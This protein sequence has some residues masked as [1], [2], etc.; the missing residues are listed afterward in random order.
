MAL[1]G[2]G[3]MIWNIRSCESGNADQIASVAQAA[4]LTNVLIKVADAAN[5]HNVDRNTKV[6]LVPPVVSALKA[7]GMQV[8]GWHYVYGYNPS[9]E[10]NTAVKRVTELGLD[11]YIID[12][13]SE[14]KL[15]G[16]EDNAR[17]FMSIV[18][19]GL[20]NIPIALCSYR[21]PSYHP[22]L[23][24][25]AFLEKCDYNMP[26]VYWEKADNPGPQLQ[27]SVR[28]FNALTPVRPV[29][30]T[31][32]IYKSGDW[33]AKPAEITAFMDMAKQLG[34]TSVNYF[35][36][37]Y[38]RTILTS[39]WDAVS[40]YNWGN[41]PTTP[42]TPAEPTTPSTPLD[43]TIV[44]N[45]IAALNAHSAAQ[46]VAL[47]NTNGAHVTATETIQGSDALTAWYTT[48]LTQTLPNAT[49]K[50]VDISGTGESIKFTWQA[51]SPSGNI[52]N[53]ADTLGIINGKITYH[54]S[55]YIITPI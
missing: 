8:W 25:Q 55:F 50:V 41:T 10:G 17:T 18:R 16:R 11:G 42:T 4:G 12:A 7:K 24:W 14:Y 36:W 13:E 45:L 53:G 43:A 19:N 33:T 1:E 28:E 38:G 3:M 48:L 47:Y 31:G 21:F 34:L 6:D 15:P 29:I 40:A 32:P 52:K 5:Y 46:V 23:P 51:V 22:Q 2:K 9:D 49:F 27:R 26:Q 54:Y 35:A 20:S 30:P 39:L 37:D 44:H